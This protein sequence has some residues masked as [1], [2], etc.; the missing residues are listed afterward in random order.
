MKVLVINCGSSSIKYQL[1][2]METEETLAKGLV[3]KIGEEVSLL[4]QQTK[5]GRTEREVKVSNHR[6]GLRLII[7][8]LL[9]KSQGVIR[10]TSE[11]SATGHRAVHGGDAFIESTLIDDM[12]IQ[13]IKKFQ[14]LAPLHNPPNLAGIEAAKNLLP[15]VPHVAVFDTAFHQTMPRKAFIY[16]LPHEFYEKHGIRRYGFHGTSHRYVAQKAAQILGR[17]LRDLKIIT[18]HLGNGCSMTAVDRGK[19]V[20]TSMGFTPLEGLPMGTRCGDIDPSIIFFIAE[21]EGLSLEEIN[22][23]LNRKSGLL[24]VSGVS[25]DVREIIKEAE[26]GNS[27]ARLALDIFAYRVKKYIGAYAAVL[28]GV[29]AL[30]FTAGIGE[31]AADIRSEICKDL[32]FL[33]VKL[34]ED[35]NEDPLK[36]QGM[37]S[38]EDSQVKVLVVPTWEEWI[39]A[40]DTLEVVQRLSGV[41]SV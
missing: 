40:R 11:I 28:G 37:V 19:S 2:D 18:C 6:Q 8:S 22:E 32:R 31:N 24:G 5:K 14:T 20:D 35:K 10:N 15:D 7:D 13:T 9:D 17:N 1:F 36:W 33:G 26:K 16:P 3:E 21:K 25:N 39:I 4:S 12:V 34:D 38:T 27:R 29:D 30:V 41:T 23:A